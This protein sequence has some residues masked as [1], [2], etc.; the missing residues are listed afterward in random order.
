M[1]HGAFVSC[2]R[3]MDSVAFWGFDDGWSDCCLLLCFWG[4]VADLSVGGADFR[5][6]LRVGIFMLWVG[7]VVF[8]LCL[9]FGFGFRLVLGG[10][11]LFVVWFCVCSC[12]SGILVWGDGLCCFAGLC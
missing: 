9:W 1:L 10:G 3:N 4:F 11:Y 8:S 6:F 2:G 5:W 12:D 7:G